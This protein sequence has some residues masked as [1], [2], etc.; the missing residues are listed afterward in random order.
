[1]QKGGN[2][3]N[4]D[5]GLTATHVYGTGGLIAGFVGL[6]VSYKGTNE[7]YG[8]LLL[9]SGWLVSAF[10]TWFVIKVSSQLTSIIEKHDEQT[11]RYAERVASLEATVEHQKNLI[12]QRLATLDFLSSLLMNTPATPRQPAQPNQR[13]NEG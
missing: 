10:M 4:V 12:D 9:A 1:M 5:H 11:A 13:A 2:L 3:S 7:I 8:W 6:L